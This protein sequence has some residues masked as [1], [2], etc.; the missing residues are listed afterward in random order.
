MKFRNR[1]LYAPTEFEIFNPKENFDPI[2]S[3][4]S[5][6]K[7]FK[8]FWKN[9]ILFKSRT[10]EDWVYVLRYDQRAKD[11]VIPRCIERFV[12]EKTIIPEEA[13]SY[14][15]MIKSDDEESWALALG[16]LR[17]FKPKKRKY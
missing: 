2:T 1:K 15:A 7:T 12:F 6:K 17:T 5:P 14:L 8:K 4:T 3:R 11:F 13:D 9:G 10:V 16:I